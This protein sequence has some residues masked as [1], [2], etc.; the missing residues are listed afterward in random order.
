VTGL[1]VAQEERFAFSY[2]IVSLTAPML[3]ALN[4]ERTNVGRTAYA[5]RVKRMLLA[6]Q[7]EEVATVLAT[8][9]AN[10]ENGT[11][12]D[13]VNWTDVAV[14][15]CQILNGRKKVIFVTAAELSAARDTVDHAIQDGY[16]VVAIPG[17]VRGALVDL[18]DLQGNPV[19]DLTTYQAEWSSSFEFNF[20]PREKLSAPERTIFDK[21]QR[22]LRLVGGLPAPVREVKISE[23][24]RPDFGTGRECRGPLGACKTTYHY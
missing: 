1:L 20:V 2:N 12:H 3:K 24:M 4:R 13:E 8:D 5:D 9:L 14:H 23:T 21:W 19:R 22:I 10:I 6:C 15:A 18:K 7:S 16:D 11:H 17:N